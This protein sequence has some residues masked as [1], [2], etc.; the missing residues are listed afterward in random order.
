[1]V[2]KRR[3]KKPFWRSVAD[4]FYPRTGWRRAINYI[5]HRVKRLPDT[6]H[7]ISLGFACGVFVCFTPLFTLHFALAAALAALFRG[8]I[9]ASLIGTFVGNPITFP[10][11]AAISYKLGLVIL[12][13]SSAEGAVAQL[14]HA[15]R[16][17]YYTL[18]TNFKSLFGYESV[19]WDGFAEFFKMVF[20]PYLVGGI[21]PGLVAAVFF[22]YLVRPMVAAY[23][24]RRK[25]RL[26]AKLKV[27][28][29]KRHSG[30]DGR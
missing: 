24:S 11:I 9:L 27:L 16:A 18:W 2:F 7:R 17:A 8:N 21:I 28:R 12:G 20:L 13:Y 10:A 23:Q 5:G 29:S 26:L 15:F 1:M 19:P 22:Y 30:A 3:D 25:G 4:M 6:P 14:R